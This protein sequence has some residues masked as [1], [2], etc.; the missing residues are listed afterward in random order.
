MSARAGII[1]HIDDAA[2]AGPQRNGIDGEEGLELGPYGKE[3]AKFLHGVN[4]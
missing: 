3:A 2:I 1:V 4:D